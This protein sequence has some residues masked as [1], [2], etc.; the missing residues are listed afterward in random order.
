M[1]HPRPAGTNVV[2]AL[3]ALGALARPSL[4]AATCTRSAALDAPTTLVLSGGGVKGAWEAGVAATLVRRGLAPRLVAGSSAGALN[5][6]LL[7]DG[8]VDRLDALWRT[9]RREQVYTLRPSAFFAGPSSFTCFAASTISATALSSS[10]LSRKAKL[11][12][13]LCLL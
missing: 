9:L 5:A 3:I 12:F 13:T 8:R 11:C 4:A 6:V 7:A 1:R 10:S 2:L